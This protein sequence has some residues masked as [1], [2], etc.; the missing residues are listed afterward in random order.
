MLRAKTRVLFLLTLFLFTGCGQK[1]AL[2]MPSKVE[3][4][5][6]K[7]SQP[8]KAKAL[9]EKKVRQEKVLQQ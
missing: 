3:T 4:K 5:A 2:Y 1:G 7:S 9:N 6:K 8:E